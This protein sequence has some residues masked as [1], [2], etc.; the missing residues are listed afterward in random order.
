MPEVDYIVLTEWFEWIIKNMNV[1]VDL[2]GKMQTFKDSMCFS[3]MESLCSSL[4]LLFKG[5]PRVQY[6]Q[7]IY[8]ASNLWNLA[9]FFSYPMAAWSSVPGALRS[10]QM[11]V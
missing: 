1:S 7:P 6:I 5:L 3:A 2:I 10:Q 4:S 11:H 8:H 9:Q